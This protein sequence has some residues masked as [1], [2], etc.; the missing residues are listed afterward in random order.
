MRLYNQNHTNA[1]VPPF[2]YQSFS[3]D[4]ALHFHTLRAPTFVSDPTLFRRALMAALAGLQH[5][6]QP[7]Q[8]PSL[9]EEVTS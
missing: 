5:Q 1:F 3:Y 4:L 2:F 8:G 9:G 7:D 6:Q